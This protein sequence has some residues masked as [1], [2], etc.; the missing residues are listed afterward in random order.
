MAAN[1]VFLLIWIVDKMNGNFFALA[2]T[3]K[4]LEVPYVEPFRFPDAERTTHSHMIK[5]HWTPTTRI[6]KSWG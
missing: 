2:A 3:K 6:A 4:T 1:G 5:D